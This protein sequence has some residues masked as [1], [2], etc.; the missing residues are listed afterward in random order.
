ML[1]DMITENS[2]DTGYTQR[3]K[4]EPIMFELSA[5]LRPALFLAGGAALGWLYYRFIG[6]G[7]G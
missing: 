1:C 4:E 5:V 6:C 3:K 2:E 7:G